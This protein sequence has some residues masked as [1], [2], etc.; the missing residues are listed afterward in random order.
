[1][2]NDSD[3]Y[4]QVAIALDNLL[5]K[6]DNDDE[7]VIPE[8]PIE[9]VVWMTL[10]GQPDIVPAPKLHRVRIEGKDQP[11]IAASVTSSLYREH[12]L[13]IHYVHVIT[14][15]G[16]F[17]GKFY[18]AAHDVTIDLIRATLQP[19]NDCYRITIEIDHD[20]APT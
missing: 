12:K 2:K 3:T 1:M 4:C 13:D 20:V 16:R 17:F 10:T 6:M 5:A 15:Q 19:L 14:A 8:G 18:F 9:E 11:G 7:V